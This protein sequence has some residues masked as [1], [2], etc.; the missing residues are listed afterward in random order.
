LI[1]SAIITMFGTTKNKT[2][3]AIPSQGWPLLT[4]QPT[5]DAAPSAAARRIHECTRISQ[6][7][8]RLC[9]RA[10][11]PPIQA[12]NAPATPTPAKITSNDPM[13]EDYVASPCGGRAASLPVA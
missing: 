5:K 6:V 9:R 11:R 10:F 2:I 12:P 13:A 4:A 3:V 1:E 7:I 8:L